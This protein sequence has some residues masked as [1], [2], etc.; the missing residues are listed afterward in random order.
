MRLV[1]LRFDSGMIHCQKQFL[2]GSFLQKMLWKER[3]LK[4]HTCPI[5]ALPNHS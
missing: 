1:H 5:D 2:K 4:V 3:K